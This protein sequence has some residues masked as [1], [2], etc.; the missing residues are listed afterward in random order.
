MKYE[1]MP[2]PKPLPGGEGDLL[3]EGVVWTPEIERLGKAIGG[4]IRM[5][6][7]GMAVDGPQRNG[8]SWATLYVAEV[9]ST[10][11]GY[12]VVTVIW[13]IPAEGGLSA[14]EFDSERM[15]QSGCSAVSYRGTSIQFG[16]HC[17][18]LAALAREAGTRRIIIFVDEAQNLRR[19][20]YNYLIHYFN[21][22]ERLRLRPFFVLVGQP[23][24]RNAASNWMNADG[25]QVV[26]RFLNRP[27]DYLGIALD[28]IDKVLAGFDDDSAGDVVTAAFRVSPDAYRRGWRIS[29][30]APLIAEAIRLIAREHNVKQELRVPMQ[31]LRATV[32]ALLYT[33]IERQCAPEQCT[34]G[35]TVSAARA[36][37]IGNVLLHYVARGD[38]SLSDKAGGS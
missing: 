18:H 36:S 28:D 8:K 20:Q 24:L 15:R 12:S 34:L 13:V 21:E 2:P 11:L 7:P 14:R 22:L 37:G 4:R 33:L 31:Y 35:D 32:L 16:R 25:H 3:G 26:G 1:S 30:L 17:D 38:S 9:L 29:A 23:E 27:H 5:D 6:L 19:A 10:I